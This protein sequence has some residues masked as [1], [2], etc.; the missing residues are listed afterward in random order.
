MKKEGQI[1]NKKRLLI[2][3]ERLGELKTLLSKRCSQVDWKATLTDGTAATFDSFEE[4]QEYSNF[5]SAKILGIKTTGRS[6]DL[7]TMITVNIS[8]EHSYLNRSGEC[9]FELASEDQYTVFRKEMQD[10]FE[11]CVE[12]EFAYQTGRW[13]L[14]LVLFVT[15]LFTTFTP[16]KVPTE[17]NFSIITFYFMLTGF[18]FWLAITSSTKLWDIFYPSIV[19]A[20]GEGVSRYEKFKKLRSHLFWGVLVASVVSVIVGLILK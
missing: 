2:T 18:S 16:I 4:L 15:V 3:N 11:K 20:I 17:I 8:R 5:G 19:F 12:D 7:K 10:F 13:L 9:R 1:I 6:D 14:T